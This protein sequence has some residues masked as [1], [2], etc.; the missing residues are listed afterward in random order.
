MAIP[1]T[2]ELL[3]TEPEN[4]AKEICENGNDTSTQIRKFY[5]DFLILKAKAD[6][7]QSEE[8][9][10][11]KILPLICFSKA[12]MAYAVGRNQLSRSLSEKINKKVDAIETRADF[13]NFL[14]YYQALIGYVTYY[15]QLKKEENQNNRAQNGKR[16]NVWNQNATQRGEYQNQGRPMYRVK[17]NNN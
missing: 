13:E 8:E 11:T 17:N 16:Q 4:L 3:T 10:K 12:K 6:I 1:L 15:A 9:F 7:A 14:N 2:K 5:N